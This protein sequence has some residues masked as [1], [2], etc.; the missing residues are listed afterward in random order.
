[1]DVLFVVVAVK[2]K[3]RQFTLINVNHVRGK[4]KPIHYW[5][6]ILSS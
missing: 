2:A 5:E 6:T 3:W 1:M 4:L